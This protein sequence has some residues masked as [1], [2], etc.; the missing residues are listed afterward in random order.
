MPVLNARGD[1]QCEGG[2]LRELPAKER[3]GSSLIC[4]SC[5]DQG[6]LFNINPDPEVIKI[7][8]A[9][10]GGRPGSIQAHFED[11]HHKNPQVYLWLVRFAREA[12][13]AG[14][15]K[16]GMSLLYE[17]LRWEVYLSTADHTTD[18]KLANNYRSRYSRLIMEQEPDLEGF[19]TTRGLK[20]E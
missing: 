4:E 10:A 8:K 7:R 9:A 1:W 18:F 13:R 12:M 11:F 14:R 15:Q 16:V 17:R 6:S 19:I 3:I 20:T 5:Q 2:C